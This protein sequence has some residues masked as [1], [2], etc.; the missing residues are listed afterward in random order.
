LLNNKVFFNHRPT[1][2]NAASLTGVSKN[3]NHAQIQVMHVL[4]ERP[5]LHG[6]LKKKIG[7]TV[8]EKQ[9]E[10]GKKEKSLSN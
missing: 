2:T 8:K 7:F 6:V 4:H 9:E 5:G 3:K 1:P 10:Y